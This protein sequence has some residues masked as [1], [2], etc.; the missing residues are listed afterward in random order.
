MAG[1]RYANVM[2][3]ACFL[4]AASNPAQASPA[5]QVD[6]AERLDQPLDP[7]LSFV[8]QQGQRVTLGSYLGAGRPLLIT[9]NYFR[10]QTLCDLQLQRLA[11]A[12]G[13]LSD[14][15]GMGFRMVTVSIDPSDTPDGAAHRRS[16]YLEQ[17]GRADLDWRFLVGAEPQIRALADQLGFRYAYDERSDQY[18]HAPVVFL[19]SPQGRIVRYL[20]GID[21]PPADLRL[22]L[23]D[24]SEGRIGRAADKLLLRCFRFDPAAGRYGVYVL[25]VVRAGA[26]LTLCAL[27]L[28][29]IG[30]RRGEARRRS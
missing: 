22:A 16:G 7:A 20:Y 8:D 3:V 6:V 30:L 4:G 2:A 17:T 27:V 1:R 18:A 19:V 9:L 26:V 11:R 14:L 10:C 5:A 15:P 28:G 13:Q 21:Y 23:I 25:G 24:A 12:V 29:F